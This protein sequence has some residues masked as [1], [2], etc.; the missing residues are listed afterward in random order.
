L[1]ESRSRASYHY[2]LGYLRASIIALVVVHHVAVGYHTAAPAGAAASLAEH[3]Y[4]M[5]AISPVVDVQRSGLLSILATFND[6]FFMELLFLLSGL[7][8][9]GSLR[10]KGWS[11]FLRGRLLRLGVPLLV[12]IALRPLTHYATYL[13]AGGEG[14]FADFWRQWGEIAW[15]GGPLWFIELLLI[16][17]IVIGLAAVIDL[18][19][20]GRFETLRSEVLASPIRSFLLLVL[21]SALVYVPIT[22]IFGSFLWL[23]VGPAQLEMNRL[24]L[25]AIY[26]LLGIVL[27]AFGIERS[28]LA[29]D[30]GLGRRWMIWTLAALSVFALHFALLLGGVGGPLGAFLYVL[31]CA[32][33]SFAFLGAFLRFARSQSKVLDSL[34]RNSYGIY[35]IHYGIVSWV[36]FAMLGLAWPAMLKWLVAAPVALA[37]CWVITALVRRIPGVARVI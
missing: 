18:D 26:F 28:F 35:V 21:L 20:S 14:G 31:A 19:W 34:D 2:P 15:R 33:I 1:T 27:G 11:G 17:N 24:P 9:W 8:V 22:S 5:R 25:Y 7:F 30:S 10:R 3:L 4:S 23:Q 29:A 36:L 37:L 16:F 32:T 12:M 6:T 13:Q